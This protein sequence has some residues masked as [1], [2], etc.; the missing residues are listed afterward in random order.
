MG[1]SSLDLQFTSEAPIAQAH[2]MPSF[3]WIPARLLIL[4][5]SKGV[6]HILITIWMSTSALDHSRSGPPANQRDRPAVGE[7]TGRHERPSSDILFRQQPLRKPLPSPQRIASS[8]FV[9]IIKCISLCF[10]LLK[11]VTTRRQRGHRP[12]S[13]LLAL[14]P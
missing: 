1:N 9:Q 5:M 10:G 2:D 3:H 14:L 4:W 11:I 12:Q 13:S 6:P 7:A 8:S